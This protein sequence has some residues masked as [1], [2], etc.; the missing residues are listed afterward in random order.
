MGSDL[1]RLDYPMLYR[2]RAQGQD[3][4]KEGHTLGWTSTRMSKRLMLSN[5]QRALLQGEFFCPCN[6][7]L[8]E[9]SEYVLTRDG[10]IESPEVADQSAGARL[11]HGDRVIATAGAVM[12]MN[13]FPAFLDEASDFAPGTYGSMLG[14]DT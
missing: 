7:T 8:E 13:E 4:D 3:H 2:M 9:A 11:A 1:W 6:K 12:L 14:W 10:G 5:F